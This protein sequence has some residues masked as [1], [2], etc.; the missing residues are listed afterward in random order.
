[1]A[2]PHPNPNP[3][4]DPNPNLTLTLTLTEEEAEGVRGR[5][6]LPQHGGRLLAEQRVARALVATQA[7]RRIPRMGQ[8]RQ[9]WA[10][11]SG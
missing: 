8:E 1:M 3:D 6:V 4:P 5:R 10:S 11:G 7:V 2:R 9:A